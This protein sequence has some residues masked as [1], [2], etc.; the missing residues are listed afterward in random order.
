MRI[1]YGL[2]IG[3]KRAGFALS[4]IQLPIPK[5]AIALMS[6][7]IGVAIEVRR[8]IS[9]SP[10]AIERSKFAAILGL[11]AFRIRLVQAA[12]RRFWVSFS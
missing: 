5:L 7:G 12:L 4:H 2:N 1:C 9:Y 8:A 11:Q 10:V 6:L 3:T